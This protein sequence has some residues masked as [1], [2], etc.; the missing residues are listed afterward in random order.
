MEATTARSRLIVLD[1]SVRYEI[2]TQ[3]KGQHVFSKYVDKKKTK[4]NIF[5]QITV[6]FSLRCF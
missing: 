3:H 5:H 1:S 6:I 2:V 4:Q